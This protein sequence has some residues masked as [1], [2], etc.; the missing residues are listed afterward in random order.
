M[1]LIRSL[2]DPTRFVR[3][4]RVAVFMPHV[5][6]ITEQ[7]LSNGAV[8]PA[9]EIVVDE[10]VLQEIAD[11]INSA[12][13]VDGELVRLTIGHRKQAADVNERLQP[14]EVGYARNYRAEM[15]NRPG[16]PQLR[17][18]QTEYWRVEFEEEC[19]LKSGRS[20]EY[21]HRNKRFRAVALLTR[22]PFLDLGTASYAA[23]EPYALYE[24]DPMPEP[25]K[26]DEKKP[27][28]V[29][30][31]EDEIAYKAFAKYMRKYQAEAGPTNTNLPQADKKP[32]DKP[33]EPI[34][35][36]QALNE[37]LL[38]SEINRQLDT[39]FYM[40][41]VRFDRETEVRSMKRMNDADRAQHLN[42]MRQTYQRLPAGQTVIPVAGVGASQLPVDTKAPL[43]E[44][45]LDKAMHYQ[46]QEGCDWPTA[47]T[48]I[49]SQRLLRR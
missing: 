13:Q 1:S 39:L 34:P 14:L 12:Y 29:W 6:T 10:A 2:D 9:Q 20:P 31:P 42:Y 5:R 4:D 48:H 47:M 7:R 40:D 28:D 44:D 15:V 3:K 38:T 43:T 22:D 27:D 49:K 18:I 25:V 16:G 8:I 35:E 45:E 24:A 23:A 37:R 30:G 33:A 41:H 21:D 19:K 46:S 17:L 11:N 32:T 36:Y 26:T